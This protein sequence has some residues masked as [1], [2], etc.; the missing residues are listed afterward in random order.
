MWEVNQEDTHNNSKATTML[1]IS[2]LL[3]ASILN[4]KFLSDSIDILCLI[5]NLDV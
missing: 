5:G 1:N 3:Q 2:T 4:K